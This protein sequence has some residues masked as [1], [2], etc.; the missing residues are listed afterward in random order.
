MPVSYLNGAANQQLFAGGSSGASTSVT[1]AIST[2]AEDAVATAAV[3]LE[4]G[5]DV[6][7]ADFTVLWGGV[8]M[9]PIE[10]G[11]VFWDSDKKTIITYKLH[12]PPL[13]SRTV[14]AA[15]TSVGTEFPTVTRSLEIVTA[16]YGGAESVSSAT[17]AGGTNTSNNQVT[18][19][20]NFEAERVVSVHGIAGVA[21]LSGYNRSLRSVASTPLNGKLALQDSEGADS[22]LM[23]C[24][25]GAVTTNWGCV[26][27]VI[28]PAP[29]Y[30]GA[31]LTLKA[32]LLA[33]AGFY[34]DV[35]P[36]E[37]RYV[38][39]GA[40]GVSRLQDTRIGPRGRP[41]ADG[42]SVM[43]YE[44]NGIGQVRLLVNGVPVGDWFTLAPGPGGV[45]A[46]TPRVL[47][48]D[49]GWP[50]RPND[51]R[52]TIF[53]GGTAPGDAPADVDNRPNDL[54]F[55]ASE[56]PGSLTQDDV[57]DGDTYVQFSEAEKAKLA[58]IEA[59]A[60]VTDY[61]NVKAAGAKMMEGPRS[62]DST[63]ATPTIDIS[64]YESLWL[65]P[66]AAAITN[67][68]V[69]KAATNIGS[70]NYPAKG[71]GLF[72]YIWDNGTSRNIALGSSFQSSDALTIPAAT[73]VGK[74]H[75]LFFLF[76]PS[77]NKYVLSGLDTF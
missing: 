19:D 15:V 7:G 6:T 38:L 65:G 31:Q 68:T 8:E 77:V 50:D 27:F 11:Q 9:E 72:L 54:W 22:L 20:A 47:T 52:Q 60:D 10:D 73:T 53:I 74:I 44:L 4:T 76:M 35:P 66:M 24:T 59:A 21:G 43:G 75:R 39:I 17:T 42:N 69:Q 40:Q 48:F 64:V 67:V 71:H 63:S 29:V 58:D 45:D 18:Q 41:G 56:P 26:S 3:K 36:D 55:P 1:H 13:G 49:G 33:N 32:S 61:T 23:K 25:N 37:S 46:Y 34:R 5:I 28:T 2:S 70:G 62:L 16:S 30:I 14:S 51:T 57:P 12:D